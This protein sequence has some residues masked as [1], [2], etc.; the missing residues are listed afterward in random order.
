M[1]GVIPFRA[2]SLT[3]TSSHD[4]LL[5]SAVSGETLEF[6]Y[7]ICFQGR[8]LIAQKPFPHPFVGSI[9]GGMSKPNDTYKVHECLNKRYD[10]IKPGKYTIQ[11]LRGM[12]A[13]PKGGKVRLIRSNI[14]TLKS[15]LNSVVGYFRSPTACYS[16]AM[17]IRRVV[18]DVK[19]NRMGESR[20]F[21]V[22]FLGLRIGMDMGSVMTFVS[23]DN[24]TAQ[25]TLMHDDG[26]SMVL[27]H[28]SVE[29]SD[30]DE[31]HAQ[32]IERRLEI[33]Y[34]LTEEPW[35]VRRFFVKDP[36]G[37]V[38][39]IMAHLLSPAGQKSSK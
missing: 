18:P 5:S 21:Y 35:G 32:A 31:V 37:T 6:D 34:P 22:D 36:N 27:P 7:E 13:K 38:L 26:T 2:R 25:I 8:D 33:V 39:N 16:H 12:P 29:V 14:V 3:N 4:L 20:A 1:D 15:C 11:A 24:P 28:M 17:P 19:S 10:I 9:E 23:P 30:I